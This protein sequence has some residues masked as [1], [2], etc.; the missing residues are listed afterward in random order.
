MGAMLLVGCGSKDAKD[1]KAEVETE[2]VPVVSEDVE[3]DSLDE[4]EQNEDESIHRVTNI[5]LDAFI[6][7]YNGLVKSADKELFVRNGN[8]SIVADGLLI[9]MNDDGTVWGIVQPI[10]PTPLSV[11][12]TLL[13]IK[14]Q[15]NDEDSEKI[16]TLLEDFTNAM[17]DNEELF[18]E[19][20]N[21][22]SMEISISTINGDVFMFNVL[23]DEQP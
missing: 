17:D 7:M 14:S 23:G 19:T 11:V 3:T 5:D 15:S 13:A 9:S 4:Q 22:E 18:I 10:Q 8:E 2:V 6:E 12:S 21:I 20:I 16:D 1:V